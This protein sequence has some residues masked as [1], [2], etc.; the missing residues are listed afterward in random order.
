MQDEYLLVLTTC[1]SEEEAGKIATALVSEKAAACCNII[2]GIRS[3]YFWLGKLEDDKEVLLLIK[4]TSALFSRLREIIAKLHSY[5][6]PEIIAIPIVE[7]S[8]SYLKWISEQ[9]RGEA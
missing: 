8:E 6:V 1:S 4:T 2:G 5:D 9:T 7:G 3:L